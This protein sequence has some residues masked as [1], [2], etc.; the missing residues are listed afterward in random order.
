MVYNKGLGKK[1]WSEDALGFYC[2][3]NKL[4]QT[5]CLKTTQLCYLT[6]MEVEVGHGCPWAEVKMLV[7]L[8]E[9]PEE[10]L[11]PCLSQLPHFLVLGL[12]SP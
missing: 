9:A 1:K 4:P 3:F 7:L 11:F 8:M 12:V 2:C 6:L 5:Y 10:D